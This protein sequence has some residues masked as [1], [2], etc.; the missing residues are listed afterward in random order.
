MRA[1]AF[2]ILVLAGLGNIR[3]SSDSD[4]IP[5]AIK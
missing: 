1:A 2:Y 4:E 3:Q 5:R